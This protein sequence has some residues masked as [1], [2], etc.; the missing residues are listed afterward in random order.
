MNSQGFVST[1]A[2]CGFFDLYSKEALEIVNPGKNLSRIL[3]LNPEE[4]AEGLSYIDLVCPEDREQ[5]IEE[6]Q[7]NPT[8][9]RLDDLSSGRIHIWAMYLK[10]ANMTMT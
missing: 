1:N 3:G 9:A 7:S 5:V 8:L 10:R 2:N 6:V 4:S